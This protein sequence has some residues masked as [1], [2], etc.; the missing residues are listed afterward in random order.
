MNSSYAALMKALI[1]SIYDIDKQE[2]REEPLVGIL[3]YKY[4]AESIS[5]MQRIAQALMETDFINT[6]TKLYLSDIDITYKDISEAL[7][8]NFNTVKSSVFYHIKK[9]SSELPK[10]L[11]F[12]LLARDDRSKYQLEKC[13]SKFEKLARGDINAQNVMLLDLSLRDGDEDFPIDDSEFDKFL[14]L[15]TPYCKKSID[16]CNSKIT[17]SMRRYYQYLLD[18]DQYMYGVIDNSSVDVQNYLRLKALLSG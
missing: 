10:T 4:S 8:K 3:K 11:I 15:I 5:Y 16:R 7:T 2:I 1:S 9:I 14:E 6:E 12:S 13:I 18:T 17:P